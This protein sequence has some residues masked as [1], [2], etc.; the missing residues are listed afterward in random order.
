MDWIELS[1]DTPNEFVEPIS[2]I[3]LRYTNTDIAII[4]NIE[5]HPDEGE[6]KPNNYSVTIKTYIEENQKSDSICTQID[7]ATRLIRYISPVGVLKIRKIGNKDW[8]N[9]WKTQFSNINIGK[10]LVIS[11]TWQKYTPKEKEIVIKL[12]PDIAF[13]TGYHPTTNMCLQLLESNI[14]T[15]MKVVDIGCGSGLLQLN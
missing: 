2:Q 3:F 12:D 9:Y 14:K 4:E 8:K 13:G 11:P 6:T 15:G 7:I 10:N 1:I 5:Y